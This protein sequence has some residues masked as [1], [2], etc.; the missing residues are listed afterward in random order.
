MGWPSR[1][2]APA[3]GLSRPLRARST[4]DL[5]APLG[6]TMQVMRAALDPEVDALQDVSPAVAG[7]DAGELD[8]ARGPFVVASRTKSSPR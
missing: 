1:V 3:R 7:P 8:H 4:V 6:P 2:I 5:P